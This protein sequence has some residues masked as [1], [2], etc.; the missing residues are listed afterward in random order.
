M[1]VPHQIFYLAVVFLKKRL[2]EEEEKWKRKVLFSYCFNKFMCFPYFKNGPHAELI[3]IKFLWFTCQIDKS[4]RK[5][6]VLSIEPICTRLI[7][8]PCSLNLMERDEKRISSY[9]HRLVCSFHT[10]ILFERDASLF[11]FCKNT[12]V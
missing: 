9:L 7:M 4:L 6:W 5:Y 3:L 8:V 12:S 10:I 1:W 11:L 2:E